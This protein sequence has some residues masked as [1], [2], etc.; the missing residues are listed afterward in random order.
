MATYVLIHGA[1]QGASTWEFVEEEL[2]SKGH[3]VYVP[4]LSGAGIRQ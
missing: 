3:R 4:I 2:R 1:W